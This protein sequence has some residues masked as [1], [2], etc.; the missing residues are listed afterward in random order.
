MNSIFL[1]KGLFLLS[2]I[3]LSSYILVAQSVSGTVFEADEHGHRVPLTGVNVFWLKT[4]TGTT[5]GANGEFVP[6]SQG[7]RDQRLVLSF[8]GYRT[9]TLPV[10]GLRNIEVVMEPDNQLL[11][12]VVVEGKVAS[13]YISSLD[14]RKV[15]VVPSHELRRAA[16]CNLAES[17]ETNAS[18]DVMYSDALTGAKQIQL[19]GLSGVYSQVLSEN[20]PLVRGL[21]SSFGLGYIP[22]TWME[23]ILI[24]KGAS[25]V[26]NGFEST[27]GQIMVEYKKPEKA[28]KL[29]LN[30]FGNSNA[31]MEVNAHTG[32][33]LNDRASTALFGHFSRFGNTFDRNND[34]F[35]DIPENTTY[36]FLNRWDYNI[37]DKLSSHLGVK[38]FD[39]TK[40]GGFTSFDPEQF[41]QD[42][43]GINNGTKPYGITM[44]TRRM[45]GYLKNGLLFKSHP[46]RSLALI[47]SGIYHKQ[48]D[49]PGL[50]RYD[51]SQKS[52]YANLLFQDRIIS[53]HHKFLTGLSLI[54]DDYKERFQR[55]D[56]TY[57]YQRYGNDLDNEPDT[58]FTIYQY[59]DTHFNF[60]RKEVVPGA[61]FEYTAHLLEK[62]TLITG[63][64]ADYHNT[65][66]WFFT[67]RM[68]FRYAFGH[69][70]VIRASA[71]KGYRT[72]NVLPENYAIMASQRR[73]NIESSLEQEN[74]W[75]FGLNFTQDLDLFGREAQLDAEAYR[76]QFLP[77][78]IVDLDS[79][80]TD[81]FIYNLDGKSFSNV[82]QFQLSFEP[83]KRLSLLAAFRF[84]D[85][86]ITENG[87]LREKAMSSKYKGL[88][89]ASY[90]TAFDNW[91]F[92]I[93]FQLNGTSRL[94]DT[95]KMPMALQ[96]EP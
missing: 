11:E 3:L 67:P 86:W 68:H 21:A 90:A 61:F 40:T 29:F 35:R 84:N 44:H 37:P 8:M 26:V 92:D 60:D 55:K 7:I 17:F 75:N 19:L 70:T 56:I 15:Q 82:I 89:T 47:L 1:K 69:G 64:R 41:T 95:D 59:S 5:P 66:G 24:S 39:E 65:Y 34:L 51:A 31:R 78:V 12:T 81:V 9:D 52:I 54:L 80:P 73:L 22:G 23:S 13:S 74:A 85:V 38:F 42:T 63:M 20:I 28:E 49:M 16:C 53:E 4:T 36:N 30:F 33:R 46:D 58:L 93:T 57:L 45:E 27:T 76:T 91:K 62:L 79:L 43:T 83:L 10:R 32:H 18:V 87:I 77:Q 94:P 96:R 71:G 48:D 6:S 14:P 72:A 50:N 25:S 88:L 2:G